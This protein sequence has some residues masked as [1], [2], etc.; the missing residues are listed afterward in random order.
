MRIYEKGG[1]LV[2]I[3]PSGVAES[4]PGVHYASTRWTNIMLWKNGLKRSLD[5]YALGQ[6]IFRNFTSNLGS[7]RITRIFALCGL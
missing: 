6:Q 7:H 5:Y 1:L 2:V 4:I 3:L